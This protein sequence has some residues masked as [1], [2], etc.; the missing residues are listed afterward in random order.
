MQIDTNT[1]K[2][3][4]DRKYSICIG[5]YFQ[6]S[7]ILFATLTLMV[8][9]CRLVWQSHRPLL[10]INHHHETY[11]AFDIGS[12]GYSNGDSWGLLP[13]TPGL[14]SGSVCCFIVSGRWAIHFLCNNSDIFGFNHVGSLKIW[15]LFTKK[16]SILLFQQFDFWS[17]ETPL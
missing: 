7:Q 11:F 10:T 6:I 17:I 15:L 8:I 9:F 16:S 2:F 5:E 1:D 14:A 13:H 12:L 3:T 4:W